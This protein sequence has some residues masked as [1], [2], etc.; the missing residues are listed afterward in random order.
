MLQAVRGC[1]SINVCSPATGLRGCRVEWCP[2]FSPAARLRWARRRQCWLMRASRVDESP[3]LSYVF[4][5]ECE[6]GIGVAAVV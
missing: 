4:R 2:F 1:A 6:Q 5:V 3:Y